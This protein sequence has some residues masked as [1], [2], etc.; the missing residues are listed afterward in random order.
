VEE[1][2]TEASVAEEAGAESAAELLNQ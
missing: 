2:V 1:A